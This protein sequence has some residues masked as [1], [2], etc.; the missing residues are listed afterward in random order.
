MKLKAA[1]YLQ[2]GSGRQSY[3]GRLPVSRRACGPAIAASGELTIKTGSIQSDFERECRQRQKAVIHAPLG[4]YLSGCTLKGHSLG[5]IANE[6][7][8]QRQPKKFNIPSLEG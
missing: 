5:R 8:S 1:V 4:R 6:D 2:A 3:K 7:S